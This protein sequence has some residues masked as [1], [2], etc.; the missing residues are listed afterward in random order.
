MH[1]G[2]ISRFC[3][4]IKY[5]SI[6]SAPIQWRCVTMCVCMWTYLGAPAQALG[7]KVGEDVEEDG[8]GKRLHA[9]TIL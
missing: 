7:V 3:N 1:I 8:T 6:L 9:H 2:H 5:W 4:F